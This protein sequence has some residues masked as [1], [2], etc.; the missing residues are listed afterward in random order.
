MGITDPKKVPTAEDV[1]EAE[2]LVNE[3]GQVIRALKE[4]NGLTNQVL[5]LL[6]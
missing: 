5:T 2:K 6:Q 1:A 4:E 3:Q